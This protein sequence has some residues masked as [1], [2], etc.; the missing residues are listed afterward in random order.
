MIDLGASV[1]EEAQVM[2]RH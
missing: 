1:V 2:C